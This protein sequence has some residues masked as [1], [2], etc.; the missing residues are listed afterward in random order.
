MSRRVQ[1]LARELRAWIWCATLAADLRELRFGQLLMQGESARGKPMGLASI[2]APA[3]ATPCCPASRHSGNPCAPCSPSL[4]PPV[5]SNPQNC[6]TTDPPP[7]GVGGGGVGVWFANDGAQ[8][9]TLMTRRVCSAIHSQIPGNVRKLAL[10]MIVRSN[11]FAMGVKKQSIVHRDEPTRRLS[12][13]NAVDKME[14]SNLQHNAC[15]T[16]QEIRNS[17]LLGS[18]TRVIMLIADAGPRELRG[19]SSVSMETPVASHGGAC[20]VKAY[21]K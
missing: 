21:Q 14:P 11:G 13:T 16:W 8:R 1:S 9:R 15:L 20:S 3:Q 2:R 17:D 7:C 18:S 5:L 12:C 4:C 10:S 19:M 6:M